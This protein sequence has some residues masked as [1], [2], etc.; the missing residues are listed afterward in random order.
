MHTLSQHWGAIKERLKQKY[1][2]LTDNDLAYIKDREEEI[3]RRI[4]EKTGAPRDELDQYVREACGSSAAS[5][6]AA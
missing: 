6:A 4:A 3:L 5:A 1:A 2:H